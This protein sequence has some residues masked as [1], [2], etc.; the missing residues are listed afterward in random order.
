MI[1][2][3]VNSNGTNNNINDIISIKRRKF[4]NEYKSIIFSQMQD[5]TE[6]SNSWE[7]IVGE[8]RNIIKNEISQ[9]HFKNQIMIE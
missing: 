4:E 6:N 9:S 2:E 5:N 1:L 3:N 7:G 8:F